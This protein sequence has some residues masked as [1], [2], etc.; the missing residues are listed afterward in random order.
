MNFF[1]AFDE[2]LQA[3]LTNFV[4]ER[5]AQLA[6][7]IGPFAAA[8][9][10]IYILVWAWLQLTGRIEQPL[11][12]GIKRIIVL[13]AILG[14]SI[15]L[16][17]YNEFF[18]DTFANSPQL[19]ATALAGTAGASTISVADAVLNDGITVGE[20]LMKQGGIL[21]GNIGFYLIGLVVYLLVGLTAGYAAF[22]SA[23][24]RVAISV[25]LAVGPLFI[26]GLLFDATRRFFEAWIAQLASYGLVTILTGAV[27]GLLMKIVQTEATQLS[28]A[29]TGVHIADVVPLLAA[30]LV[31]LLVMRQIMPMSAGLASGVALASMGV[32]S[33]ALAWSLGRT[34]RFA[35]GL[36]DRDTSRWDPASRKIG[37]YVARPARAAIGHTG[38]AIAAAAGS[39][40][41]ARNVIRGRTP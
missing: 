32:V 3:Q 16:W 8:C 26:V 11:I 27:A 20:N 29:G 30:C 41:R 13:A 25:I 21:N 33:N 17:S 39:T 38:S 34:A 37:Y 23:L 12:E 4:A 40:L 24:A 18:V 7:M 9:A 22:L 2:W 15:N 5:S 1:A 35:R 36:T 31:V 28:E 6:E 14:F 10:V 19:L